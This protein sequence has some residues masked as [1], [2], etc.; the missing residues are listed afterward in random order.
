MADFRIDARQLKS[1]DR[2][3]ARAG[4]DF[5]KGTNRLL[6]KIGVLVLGQARKNAPESP[7]LGQYARMNKSGKTKRKASSITTGSLRDSIRT[8]LG[9]D[10]VS[11][12]VPAN[13]RGG[14]YAEKMHDEKGKTWKNRG[15][16]TK[17]KGSQAGDKYI[18]RA[19]EDVGKEV[20][21]LIDQ[22]A[23]ELIRRI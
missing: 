2:Q 3:L 11:I 15:P 23:N 17:E 20:D 7:T 1:L 22:V 16:R 13:S 19:A 10:S 21:T 4:V 8:D 18:Y 14:K 9:K 5:R 6:K 12:N